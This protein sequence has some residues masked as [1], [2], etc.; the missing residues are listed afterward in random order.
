MQDDH[1][2]SV[3][4]SSW[5]KT[6]V[7]PFEYKAVRKPLA[8]VANQDAI[9]MLWY[10]RFFATNNFVQALADIQKDATNTA[11]LQKNFGQTDISL[12]NSYANQLIIDLTFGGLTQT[13]KIKDLVYGFTSPLIIGAKNMSPLLGGDPTTPTV[14]SLMPLSE[15]MLSERYTGKEDINQ[16]DQY[17]TFWGVDYINV[18]KDVYD[19]QE[20]LK[21]QNVNPWKSKVALK[22][23]DN[24]YPPRPSKDKDQ[25]AFIFD[26]YRYSKM[27]YNKDVKK[28]AGRKALR[29]GMDNS[30]L[31]NSKTNPANDVYYSD[32]Y[33]GT[34]NLTSAMQAP[35]FI[36]RLYLNG[37]G[38]GA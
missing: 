30:T 32:K 14:V 15:K 9:D 27:Q 6:I 26:L 35:M 7:G 21:G 23:S 5:F 31:A 11:S 24:L 28:P 4:C 37:V 25:Y 18:Y 2:A 13:I 16:I 1:P 34:M 8:A 10:D 3:S 33:D 12:F 19:G 36:S 20:I 38:Q 29:F 22:G 17:L